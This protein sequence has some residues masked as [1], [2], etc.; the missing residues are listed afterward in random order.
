MMLGQPSRVQRGNDLPAHVLSLECQRGCQERL[1]VGHD[2]G[3][4][5]VQ[6]LGTGSAGG[7][8][9]AELGFVVQGYASRMSLA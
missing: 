1:L 9:G 6:L 4:R 2:A 8:E 3:E 5:A 7:P